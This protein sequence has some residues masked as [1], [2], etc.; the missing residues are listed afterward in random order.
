MYVFEG[1]RDELFGNLNAVGKTEISC[2]GAVNGPK[3]SP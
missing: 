2:F 3:G 1:T